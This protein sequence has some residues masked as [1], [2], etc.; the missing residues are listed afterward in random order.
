MAVPLATVAIKVETEGIPLGH[1]QA[2][3]RTTLV[4][5]DPKVTSKRGGQTDSSFTCEGEEDLRNPE[6][7]GTETKA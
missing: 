6:R 7:L 4:H 2:S 5:W 3:A 1:L